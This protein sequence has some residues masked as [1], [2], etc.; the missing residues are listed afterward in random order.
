MFWTTFWL[1]VGLV[2]VSII[3]YWARRDSSDQLFLVFFGGGALTMLV[4]FLRDPAEILVPAPKLVSCGSRCDT[5]RL[6]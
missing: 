3:G 4:F 1:G 2:I 6:K 5:T